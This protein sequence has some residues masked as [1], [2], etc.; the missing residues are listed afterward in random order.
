MLQWQ[1]SSDDVFDEPLHFP[2]LYVTYSTFD[3]TEFNNK[4]KTTVESVRE[5]TFTKLGDQ[6][7]KAK[8]QVIADV[9]NILNAQKN[10]LLPV[11]YKWLEKY[12]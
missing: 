3:D 6:F 5:F 4:L 2:P 7:N 9:Y 12:K 8:S 10:V 11:S 1:P